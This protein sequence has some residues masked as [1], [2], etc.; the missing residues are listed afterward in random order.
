MTNVKYLASFNTKRSACM[1]KVNGFPV[2]ENF[3]YS[4]GTISTGFNITAFVENGNNSIELMMGSIDPD[5]KNTLYSDSTCELTITR[6][7]ES[8]SHKVTSLILSVD[9]NRH[10][11]ASS[12]SN[13]H[14]SLNEKLVDEIQSS[15][16]KEQ[17]LYRAGREIILSELPT[18]SWVNATP[19][20]EDYLPQ[21]RS[22]Y[23]EIWNAMRNRDIKILKEIADISSREMGVAEGVSSD[24]IFES[25][26]LPK[27]ILRKDLSPINL[28]WGGYK[29]IT[30]CNG[31]VF[32]LAKGIYQNSPLRLR[33]SDG[34]IIFSYNPYFSIIDGKVTLVR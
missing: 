15:E 20:S 34:D 1:A 14:G 29:I 24:T 13:Y 30:Y 23:K 4:S 16:S 32:R 5:D 19:F 33:D 3:T 31:R 22:I 28:D 11:T 17:E 26:N 7:T 2:I 18:W 21:T 25:Y 10:I 6:D 27:N 12:S 9:E 8:S